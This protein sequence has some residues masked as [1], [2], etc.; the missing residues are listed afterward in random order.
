MKS[1]LPCFRFILILLV[2]LTLFSCE[3]VTQS[4]I[5]P[6]F[7]ERPAGLQ[8]FTFKYEFDENTFEDDLNDGQNKND[9][10]LIDTLQIKEFAKLFSSFFLNVYLFTVNGVDIKTESLRLQIPELDRTIIRAVSLESVGIYNSKPRKIGGKLKFFKDF[11]LNIIK[12]D[13]S[14]NLISFQQERYFWDI[15]N[16]KRRKIPAKGRL[17]EKNNRIVFQTNKLNL[18]DFLDESGQLN[19]RPFI[20]IGRIPYFRPSLKGYFVFKV[21]I[22]LPF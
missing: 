14:A 22:N 3:S 12:G 2:A 20:R 5:E 13:L 17:L 8:S 7:V 21:D 18:L 1:N 10:D 9:R 6:S 4:S 15:I 11:N 16:L 19:F